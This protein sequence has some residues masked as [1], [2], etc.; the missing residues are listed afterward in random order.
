MI[1]TRHASLALAVV[2]LVAFTVGTGGFSS[3]TVE[4][5]VTIAVADDEQA[6][7]GIAPVNVTVTSGN[8]TRLFT[9]T[10]RFGTNLTIDA[11]VNDTSENMNVAAVDMPNR[12]GGGVSGPVNAT[13]ACD[14]NATGTVTVRIDASGAGVEVTMERRVTVECIAAAVS[15]TREGNGSVSSTNTTA[16]SPRT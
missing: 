8:E 16:I 14:E 2:V 6:Y 12:L 3:A 9:L 10:N 7:L 13:V 11:Q 1:R 15:A 4:R 5:G